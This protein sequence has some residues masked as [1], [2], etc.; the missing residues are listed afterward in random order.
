M[1]S[2]VLDKEL[3]LYEAYMISSQTLK[4]YRNTLPFMFQELK[5]MRATSTINY[6]QQIL[7]KIF[8]ILEHAS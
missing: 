5:F 7:S 1:L 6:L 2:F 3:A 8:S 4:I